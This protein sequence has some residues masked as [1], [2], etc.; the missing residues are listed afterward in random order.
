MSR[1]EQILRVIFQTLEQ[2]VLTV[3]P[4][5]RSVIHCND[6]VRRV[7][8]REPEEV[9]GRSTLQLHID[10]ASHAEFGRISEEVLDR[11]KSFETE[12]QFRRRDGSVFPAEITVTPISEERSWLAGVV[13]VIRD[14]SEKKR[15]EH[16]RRRNQQRLRLITE[17]LPAIIW[18]TDE[19]LSLTSLMGNR[20]VGIAEERQWNLNQKVEEILGDG[21]G[22]ILE[23]H[24]EALEGREGSFEFAQGERTFRAFTEPFYEGGE[25]GGVLGIATD[26]TQEYNRLNEKESLIREIEH[27]VKNNL[28]L[29]RSILSLQA[30]KV[31]GEEATEALRVAGS[32]V[33]TLAKVYALLIHEE[34]GELV[35]MA[36]YI[37][38]LVAGLDGVARGSITFHEE[39]EPLR[40]SIDSAVPCGLIVHELIV[41]A[42]KHAFPQKKGGTV[43]ISLRRQEGREVI[44]TVADNGAGI[45]E[46]TLTQSES[47]GLLII[48][49]LVDQIDG[50]IA[51]SAEKGTRVEV[52]FSAE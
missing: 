44:L 24:R 20:R 19:E 47:V 35:D 48:R 14:V 40:L 13:S 27:R 52:R 6:A 39:V 34:T 22:S 21:D 30:G 51:I 4:E 25:I 42:A 23:A 26:V 32:R 15:Q 43:R 31:Q 28:Q 33:H 11:G 29:I 50:A 7:F 2:V 46:K 36:E 41:N 37:H 49:S 8:G 10:A 45:S 18:S 38:E 9:I 5:T 16:S 3:D 17:Q 12:W 1:E